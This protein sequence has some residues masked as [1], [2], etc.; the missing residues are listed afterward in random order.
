M[1]LRQAPPLLLPRY[2]GPDAKMAL[3]VNDV[4]R[5]LEAWMR[6]LV[7]PSGGHWSTANVTPTRTLDPTTATLAQ[8]AQALATL[9]QDQQT[10]GTIT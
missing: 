3:W 9:I 2:T 8:V 10:G 7:A 5:A 1:G 4:N 6:E